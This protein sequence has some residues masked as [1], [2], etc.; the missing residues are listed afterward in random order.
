LYMIKD[1]EYI[2]ESDGLIYCKKCK[3][4]RQ[5]RLQPEHLVYIRC[6]CQQ[7]VYNK[8]QAEIEHRKET[9]RTA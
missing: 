1:D 4:P 3:T 9:K 5:Y 7:E 2:N 8:E 6:K